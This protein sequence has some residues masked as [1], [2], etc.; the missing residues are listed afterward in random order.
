MAIAWLVIPY[1]IIEPDRHSQIYALVNHAVFSVQHKTNSRSKEE[2]EERVSHRNIRQKRGRVYSAWAVRET[3]FRFERSPICILRYNLVGR[4][5]TIDVPFSNAIYSV[6]S[7]FPP[8]PPPNK[9]Q[10]TIC[11][12]KLAITYNVCRQSRPDCSPA[13]RQNHGLHLFTRWWNPSWQG[14]RERAARRDLIK[15]LCAVNNFF[16]K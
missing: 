9:M 13:W 15:G 16:V 7:R 5:T 11:Q 4:C 1:I 3:K 14:M 6:R 8:L 10:R 12:A 2:S